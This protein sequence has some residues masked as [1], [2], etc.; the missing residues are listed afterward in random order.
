MDKENLVKLAHE[1]EELANKTQ[2][3]HTR[4]KWYS[5]Q[6]ENCRRMASGLPEPKVD[7][8]HTQ[9]YWVKTSQRHALPTL[10]AAQSEP[11]SSDQR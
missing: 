10:P 7:S 3:D 5:H 2:N 1:F 11:G 8:H 9:F 4:R 6:A